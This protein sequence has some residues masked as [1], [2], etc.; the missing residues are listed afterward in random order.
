MTLLSVVQGG[1]FS[2]SQT[3]LDAVICD[4]LPLLAGQLTC[5]EVQMTLT[6]PGVLPV[7]TC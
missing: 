7:P 3:E 6:L 1:T 5:S 2:L 4:L